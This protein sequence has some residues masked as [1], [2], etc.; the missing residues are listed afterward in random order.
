VAL[1]S[2]AGSAENRTGVSSSARTGS[3]AFVGHGPDGW[4]IRRRLEPTAL[5]RELSELGAALALGDHARAVVP[6][7]RGAVEETGALT[8]LTLALLYHGARTEVV[9]PEEVEQVA[10]EV[11]PTVVVVSGECRELDSPAMA[12]G[13]TVERVVELCSGTTDELLRPL[14]RSG[15]RVVRLDWEAESAAA[16]ARFLPRA[17]EGTT[18]QTV[19]AGRAAGDE[20]VRIGGDFTGLPHLFANV[21]VV[22]TSMLAN[23]RSGGRV[24]VVPDLESVNDLQQLR[25]R[26][27][28]DV[29]RYNT[30]IELSGRVSA[31]GISLVPREALATELEQDG[32]VLWLATR[33]RDSAAE[34]EDPEQLLRE[35]VVLFSALFDATELE[36]FVRHLLSEP[37]TRERLL[38]W[39]RVLLN[40]ARSGGLPSQVF[41]QSFDLECERRRRPAG[42]V[43][44]RAAG[45][46]RYARDWARSEDPEGRLLPEPV[47]AAVR[48]G[49][50]A[51]IH[52]FFRYGLKTTVYGSAYVPASDNF[53]VV[54]NHSS[55]LD[56]GLVQYALGPWRHKLHTL[57]AKDYFFSTPGRRFIAHHFTRLI[58]TD[59][60]RV[61][62]DW[63]RRARDLL[64]AGECVLIFPEGTRSEGT[65]VRPF[66]ASL[67]TLVRA[68]SVPVL[69]IYVEGSDRILPKGKALPRG[70][71]INVHVGPPL[72]PEY[73][74]AV[75]SGVP[76]LKQD[77]A[78]AALLQRAVA[79]VPDRDFWWLHGEL[80]SAEPL[81]LPAMVET[82]E[83]EVSG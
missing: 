52:T 67:G 68:S 64:T 43:A 35:S 24:L 51:A 30:A 53:L 61:S 15:C 28:R 54:A 13:G 59:R 40:G 34:A 72:P 18:V 47:N 45:A 19:P 76:G 32:R 82:E 11:G 41:L 60:Q 39:E 70:R 31:V 23:G 78:I 44:R 37:L 12:L 69:P 33:R 46:V 74:T 10:R 25:E 21:P 81:M 14:N 71:E 49:I 75:T 56:A 65:D 58:P 48:A 6:A 55:H 27:L 80:P 79:S 42:R 62:S 5:S 38:I 77:R 4:S 50:G 9:R 66:K 16:S 1:E 7:P 83:E 73:L 20:L 57:A 63:L 17:G 3:I 29:T 26:L 8:L 22:S 36:F 2:A